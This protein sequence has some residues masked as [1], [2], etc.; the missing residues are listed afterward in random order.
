MQKKGLEYDQPYHILEVCNP[1][2]AQRVLSQNQLVGYV[3]P[4]KVAIYKD[5]EKTKIGMPKPTELMQMIEDET[6]E[7]IAQDIEKRLIA[8]IN[9]AI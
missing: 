7:K 6:I 8:C 4:C 1:E 9:K 2:A 3:L 5:N